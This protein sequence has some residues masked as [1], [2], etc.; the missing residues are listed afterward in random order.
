MATVDLTQTSVRKLNQALHDLPKDATGE[1]EINGTKGE[2][3]VAIETT[4]LTALGRVLPVDST[5]ADQL[6]L[7][8]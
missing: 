3:A 1:R 8:V 2:H 5:P 6:R 7:R 4:T